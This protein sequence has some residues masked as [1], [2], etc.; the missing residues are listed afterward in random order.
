M[1]QNG[2]D[3]LH[4][5][6]IQLSK[7]ANTTNGIRFI[8]LFFIDIMN[9]PV[10]NFG[11]LVIQRDGNLINGEGYRNHQ[12]HNVNGTFINLHSLYLHLV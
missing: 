2:K 6:E 1:S 3:I 11:A 10:P 12:V 8:D 5:N 4:S 7:P 9:E